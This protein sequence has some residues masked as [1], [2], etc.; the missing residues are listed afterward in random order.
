MQMSPEKALAIRVRRVLT[1]KITA[2]KVP[3]LLVPP[4]DISKQIL[5]FK[6]G[7]FHHLIDNFLVF[8]M[9]DNAL[10]VSIRKAVYSIR[11]SGEY[12]YIDISAERISKRECLT[13][14]RTAIGAERIR[15]T[16]SPPI[17]LLAQEFAENAH[18][19]KLRK[20]ASENRPHPTKLGSGKAPAKTRGMTYTE[21]WLRQLN[22]A[23]NQTATEQVRK[24]ALVQLAKIESELLSLSEEYF[25][26]PSTEALNGSGSLNSFDAPKDGILSFFGYQVGRGSVLTSSTRYAILDRVFTLVLPPILPSWHMDSWGTPESSRRLRKMAETIAALARN[27]K[28]RRSP[29]YDQAVGDWEQDLQRLHDTHYVGRFDFGWP[30]THTV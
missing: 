14:A 26:W 12:L 24:K 4:S 8:R 11:Y 22:L 5:V 16:P 19:F 1:K 9:P 13:V 17:H 27:A 3:S 30:V 18:G 15:I 28:H 6:E 20:L 2:Q 29:S 7:K 25:K 10:G 23:F 21:R